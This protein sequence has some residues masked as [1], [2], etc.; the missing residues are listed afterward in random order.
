MGKEMKKPKI[1]WVVFT[2]DG[3]QL[4]EYKTHQEAEA[5][6]DNAFGDYVQRVLVTAPRRKKWASLKKFIPKP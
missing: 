3:V 6:C 5:A 2:E 1:K 4:D